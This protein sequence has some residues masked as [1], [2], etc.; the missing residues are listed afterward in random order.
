[1]ASEDSHGQDN[2]ERQPAEA[3][4]A[5]IKSLDDEAKRLDE[6]AKNADGLNKRRLEARSQEV[7]ELSIETRDVLRRFRAGEFEGGT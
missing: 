1:M 6:Q 2:T 5:S 3:L 7:A 4:R